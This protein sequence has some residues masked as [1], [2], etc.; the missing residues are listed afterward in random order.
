MVGA[1]AEAAWPW[2]NFEAVPH[3]QGQRRSPSKM[4]GGGK[5]CLES[6]TI[7]ARDARRAQ[8]KPCAHQDPETPQ[9]L[10]QTCV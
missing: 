2:N 6:N 9:R 8:A 1:E 10:S 7:P 5:L 4:V 3:I